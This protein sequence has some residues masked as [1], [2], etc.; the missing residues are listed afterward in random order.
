MKSI[1]KTRK[2]VF[3]RSLIDWYSH[4]QRKLPWRITKDPY[5]ILVSEIMLQQT[6]VKT[7]IPY[8]QRW[9]TLFPDIKTLSLASE[10][11]V[12]KTWQ[13][14]GYYRRAK[15]LHKTAK[16]IQVK[17]RGKIPDDYKTLSLLPGIGP[18]TTAAVLS[19][20]YNKPYPVIDANVRRILMRLNRF[21]HISDSKQD[22]ILLSFIQPYLPEEGMGQ[23]NQALMELGAMVCTPKNPVCLTC[24]ITDFCAAY[25]FGEQEVIPLPKKK[26]SQKIEAVVGIIRKADKFLIQK[27]PSSGLL[28][29][30]WEFPGGKRQP[31]ETLI[32]ALKREI[33]E[34][35]GMDVIAADHMI[36]VDHAYTDY[37]VKLHAFECVV[38]HDPDKVKYH[39]SKWVT[40]KE[41][42]QYPFPSGSVKIIKHLT[43]TPSDQAE[44]I[45][46]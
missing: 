32:E 26:S 2:A 7:V 18:Y 22:K 28:A 14:L 38:S 46:K 17:Y 3:L 40:L 37:K 29:D 39:R 34:E 33:K 6:T 5:R 43:E 27:R 8:Y 9:M 1:S 41:M 25:K 24:P 13:G 11:R 23:F 42:E 12:L 21:K 20:A 35:T 15:N 4:H 30:L 31:E 10:Q 44:K 36:T 19:M 45:P 16:M